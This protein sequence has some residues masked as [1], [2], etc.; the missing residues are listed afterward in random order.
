M[1]RR[2]IELTRKNG[3]KLAAAVEEALAKPLRP[4][5]PKLKT[6]FAFVEL[7]FEKT[8][9]AA[10]L[11]DFSSK[12]PHYE[13]WAKRMLAK[14]QAGEMFPSSYPY[15]VQVWKLGDDQ[16]W[17]S[18]GGE[19]VVDYSLK[20]ASLFGPSTWTNGSATT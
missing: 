12:G 11:K 3:L 9:T 5:K 17:I 18:I 2:T 13:R 16:P 6:A 14:L 1:P 19:P 20:F 7:P 10:D 4:L 8:M 15:A